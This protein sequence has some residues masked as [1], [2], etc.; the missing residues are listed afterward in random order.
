MPIRSDIG[1]AGATHRAGEPVFEIGQPRL[2]RP[3]VE[4]IVAGPLSSKP[5]LIGN[6]A[7][8]T[9]NVGASLNRIRDRLLSGVKGIYVIFPIEYLIQ[10]AA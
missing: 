9:P 3:L 10:D 7:I 5:V 6:R 4:V 2:V 1:T 8:S